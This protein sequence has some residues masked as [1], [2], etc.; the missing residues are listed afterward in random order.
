M[1]ITGLSAL[2]DLGFVSFKPNY[3]HIELKLGTNTSNYDKKY[4]ITLQSMNT[5]NI[6][7]ISINNKTYYC[8]ERLFIEIDKYKIENTIK[9]EALRKLEKEI[10]PQKVFDIY[11]KI[12][13]KRRGLD[14]ERIQSYF[15]KNLLIP[16]EIFE[17]KNDIDYTRIIREYIMSIMAT[18]EFPISLVKGGS[19]IELYI[20]FKRAT[21]DIDAHLDHSDFEKVKSI[22][23]NKE[24]L[25]YFDILNLK[26]IENKLNENKKI[27]MIELKAKS[28]KRLIMELLEKSRS[29]NLTLNSSFTSDELKNII[30]DF[31]I[32]KTNLKTI[33]NGKAIVFTKEMI[34]AEKYH[35]LIT[36]M[37]NTKRTK[38]LIDIVN[39]YDGDID[40]KKVCEWL[41]IKWEKSKNPL[42]K[43]EIKEF[44]NLHK[45]DEFVKI[46]DNYTDAVD[47]Y[48]TNSTYDEAI[49]IFN[50]LSEKILKSI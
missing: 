27:I 34:L 21:E 37:K 40:F 32:S 31:S 49:K 4:K 1:I 20:N 33:K 44:I 23:T 38:D 35:S 19:A 25:I 13:N 22:L 28:R 10:N 7:T 41:I 24:V 36:K 47:M 50:H 8:P 18:K 39:I 14:K 9:Q 17:N 16:Q 42:S 46:K 6:G 2:Y 43:N 29:I 30:N 15:D 48:G 26:E 45:N 5:L 12:K 3:I 11:Q